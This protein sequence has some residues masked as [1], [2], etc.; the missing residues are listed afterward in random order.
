MTDPTMTPST[1]LVPSPLP[2]K[3]DKLGA[4]AVL[5]LVDG[6]LNV[7]YGLSW[8]FG[9]F[10]FGASTCG[11]GCLFVPLGAYPLVLGILEI[12][13]ASRL[14]PD[15]PRDAEPARWL[16]VMQ[17]I[18]VLWGQVLSLVVGILLLIF[19]DDPEV[20]DYLERFRARSAPAGPPST[21]TYMESRP[22]PPPAPPQPTPGADAAAPTAEP[23]ADHV[24]D[25]NA[26]KS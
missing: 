9:I 3:P 26:P 15:P 25:E 8:L 14:L 24:D 18:N 4:I 20:R 11:L 12:L 1:E 16:A 19:F 2:R 13:Y 21:A 17:I 23:T 6:I 7:V 10:V 22:T 5:T